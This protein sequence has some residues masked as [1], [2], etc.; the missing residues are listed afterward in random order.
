MKHR[1]TIVGL[2]LLLAGGGA[3]SGQE[4]LDIKGTWHPADGAHIVEGPSRHSPSGTEDVLGNDTLK[5]HTSKF[6]FRFDG[7]EGRTFWGELASDDVS[8]KL[9]GTLSVDG[10]RFVIADQDGTFDGVVVDGDTLDYCYSHVTPTNR[11]V[12]CGLLVREK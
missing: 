4:I 10:R 12:A 9:I 6:V 2:A 1:G 8:E 5:Q 11:A 7:Q 3:A